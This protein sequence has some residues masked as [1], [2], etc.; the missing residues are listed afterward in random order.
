MNGLYKRSRGSLSIRSSLGDRGKEILEGEGDGVERKVNR[1]PKATGL[2]FVRCRVNVTS[3]ADV[4]KPRLVTFTKQHRDPGSGPPTDATN[5]RKYFSNFTST[6]LANRQW[7]F[8]HAN[9]GAYSNP[10]TQLDAQSKDFGAV[11][12]PCLTRGLISSVAQA[13]P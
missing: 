9:H 8:W 12:Q 1:T 7:L 3:V 6:W 4:I 10:D 5:N 13:M 2:K 11:S